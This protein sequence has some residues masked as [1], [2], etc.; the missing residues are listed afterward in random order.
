L[1]FRKHLLYSKNL[2]SFWLRI[3]FHK[4]INK[5]THGVNYDD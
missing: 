2:I 1:G 5:S 4:V 3:V